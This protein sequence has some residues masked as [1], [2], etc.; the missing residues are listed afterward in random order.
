[1]GTDFQIGRKMHGLLDR[2]I[3]MQTGIL[4]YKRHIG[5]ES[6]DITHI[7]I[8]RHIAAIT[9]GS[10]ICCARSGW[11][12]KNKENMFSIRNFCRFSKYEGY[13]T[14]ILRVY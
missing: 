2:Q 4:C 6:F 7:I 3:R 9:E 13:F 14:Y 8:D 10:E 1:M 5:L 11:K 12:E